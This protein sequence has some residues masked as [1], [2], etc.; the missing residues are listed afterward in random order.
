MNSFRRT[1]AGFALALAGVALAALP[2]RAAAREGHELWGAVT[3][4]PGREGVVL[5][6]GYSGPPLGAGSELRL[7][8]PT[9]TRVTDT[10]LADPGYRGAV[11]PGGRAASYTAPAGGPWRER[12]FPFALA[13]P[14]D[15]VPGTRPAGCTMVLADA[16]GVPRDRGT[17]AVTV[18][19]PVPTVTLPPP[20]AVLDVRPEVSGTAHPGAQITVRD[21]RDGE[22]CATTADRAGAW[23][24][25]PALP[26]AAGPGTLRATAALGGVAATSPPVTV[27]V[28]AHSGT[29]TGPVPPTDG[30]N[31]G[32]AHS[33]R[34]PSPARC[35]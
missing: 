18:G 9:G 20:G 19:M 34:T 10:P 27:T 8:P 23:S 31:E 26:L 30:V 33:A 7:T 24:C 12:A 35:C 14:A 25:V 6:T 21:A 1:R 3:I 22:V 28:E 4:L 29:G 2:G 5:I 11:A 15:A 16:W 17:C 13:V 32:R